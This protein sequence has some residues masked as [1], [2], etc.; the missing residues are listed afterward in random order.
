MFV[1]CFVARAYADIRKQA[2]SK[3][4][5]RMFHHKKLPYGVQYELAR[6]VS[7]SKFNFADIHVPDLDIFSELKTNEKAAPLTLRTFLKPDE[8]EDEDEDGT[9]GSVFSGKSTCICLTLRKE[10]QFRALFLKEH[11][12]KVQYIFY[13]VIGG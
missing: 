3:I 1:I 4:F 8:D 7:H 13:Y 5:Q 6:C 12:A 10:D 2:P 9:Q 11:A